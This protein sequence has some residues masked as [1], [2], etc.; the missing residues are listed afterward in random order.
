[1]YEELFFP[2]HDPGFSGRSMPPLN[3]LYFE[4][5]DPSFSL[6]RSSTAVPLIAEMG[7]SQTGTVGGTGK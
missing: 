4:A 6:H 1:M 2:H 7:T 3:H 5:G